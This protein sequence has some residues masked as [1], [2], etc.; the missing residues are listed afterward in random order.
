MNAGTTGVC[1]PLDQQVMRSFMVTLRNETSRT[2]FSSEGGSLAAEFKK[3]VL[4]PT[5]TT[6]IGAAIAQFG[7]QEK[8]LSAAWERLACR[9]Q[10]EK[11]D[12]LEQADK[13]HAACLPFP[14]HKE[15][16]P[17]HPPAAAAAAEARC[18]GCFWDD[19]DGMVA[20]LCDCDD[21]ITDDDMAPEEHN[22][23]EPAAAAPASSSAGLVVLMDACAEAVA[24]PDV[25]IISK[26]VALRCVYGRGLK[27]TASYRPEGNRLSSG[28]DCGAQQIKKHSPSSSLHLLSH[29]PSLLIAS[30]GL[31]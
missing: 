6:W 17:G 11:E 1:H 8:M 21:D 13:D 20:D 15:K 2:V 27:L 30:H 12:V 14:S 18:L 5:L 4:K 16:V 10:A 28:E 19:E 22:E 24:K 23:A 29:G 9:T 26:F 7:K 3:L 25:S 31:R